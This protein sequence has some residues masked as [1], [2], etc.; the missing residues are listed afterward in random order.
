[1]QLIE[2]GLITLDNPFKIIFAICCLLGFL[3][4]LMT[5]L[6]NIRSV[7]PRKRC[8]FYI[9]WLILTAFLIGL[10]AHSSIVW[11][12]KKNIHQSWRYLR[13]HDPETLCSYGDSCAL[14]VELIALKV[15][16]S[17]EAYML[18]HIFNPLD[19]TETP[20]SSSPKKTKGLVAFHQLTKKG[21]S[22]TPNPSEIV[23]KGY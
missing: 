19:L 7:Q 18:D 2:K 10:T 12:S 4:I 8:Q 15:G 16:Q 5:H 11:E 3:Q 6:A 20:F 1:M 22:E 23:A 14:L 9:L 21:F 17:I 13:R